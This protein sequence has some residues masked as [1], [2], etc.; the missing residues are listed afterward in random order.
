[1]KASDWLI[2]EEDPR[3]LLGQGLPCTV[4]GTGV[5]PFGDIEAVCLHP[6]L[7]HVKGEDGQPAEDTSEATSPELL[8]L[9]RL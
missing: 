2:P 1:M 5:G 3:S 7:D 9:T 4:Q 6:G 8:H